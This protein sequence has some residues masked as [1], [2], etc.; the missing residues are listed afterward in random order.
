MLTDIEHPRKC[1]YC[2]YMFN[3]TRDWQ[4][5]CTDR[6][7]RLSWTMTHP[8]IDLTDDVFPPALR[9]CLMDYI[10]NGKWPPCQKKEEAAED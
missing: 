5:H 2:G 1:E 3:P 6:C 10:Q 8:R 9:R 4:K 7:R